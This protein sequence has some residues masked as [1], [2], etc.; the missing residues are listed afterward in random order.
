MKGRHFAY[1]LAVRFSLQSHFFLFESVLVSIFNVT[2][3]IFFGFLFYTD[4]S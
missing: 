4:K 2:C 3:E 1:S